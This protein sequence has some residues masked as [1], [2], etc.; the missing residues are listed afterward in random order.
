LS[1]NRLAA[2]RPLTLLALALLVGGCIDSAL[3]PFRDRSVPDGLLVTEGGTTLVRV[4]KNERVS[5]NLTVA[6]GK[7]TG[8]LEVTFLDSD[9]KRIIPAGDESLEVTIAHDDVA[10]FEQSVPGVFSGRL[11]GKA[12]G[13]TIA[14]FKLKHGTVYGNWASPAIEITVTR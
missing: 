6:A 7:R 1:R 11:V 14:I 2:L 12:A 4:D 8:T 3:D 5:G 10:V 13:S 9:G